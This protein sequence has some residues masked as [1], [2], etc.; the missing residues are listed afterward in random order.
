VPLCNGPSE[1]GAMVSHTCFGAAMVVAVAA[2]ITA[3]TTIAT[4]QIGC[5]P[6]G[7]TSY[8]LLDRNNMVARLVCYVMVGAI[9]HKR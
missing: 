8:E 9:L 6:P 3:T 5:R 4:L 2:A 1:H 7:T